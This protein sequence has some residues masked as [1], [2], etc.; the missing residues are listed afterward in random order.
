M[1]KFAKATALCAALFLAAM[2]IIDSGSAVKGARDALSL[3]SGVLIPSLFPFMVTS[4]FIADLPLPR[5]AEAVLS[6]LMRAAFR[7]PCAAAPAVIF[8]LI[9][10][11][12]VGARMAQRLFLRGEIT[13]EQAQR[14]LLFCVNAGPAFVIGT[15]GASLLS[16]PEAGVILFASLSISSLLLGCFL[17]FMP[18]SCADSP[19]SAGKKS[20]QSL[21]L[22]LVNA[23]SE[24]SAGIVSV[25]AWVIFFGSVCALIPPGAGRNAALCVLEVTGG[26][27]ESAGFSLPVTASVL[28]FGGL[29]VHCQC[30][31]LA[32]KIPIKPLMFFSARVLNAVFAA[33]IC[34]GLTRVF[35]QSI[36]TL[37]HS[38][39]AF[40]AAGAAYPPAAC[41]L[42]FLCALVI[43]DLDTCEKVC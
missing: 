35:P 16:S 36:S 14:L 40:T 19:Q 32:S 23:V 39:E 5:K 43:L 28:G 38:G 15:V 3:C 20:P 4:G 13:D 22:S 25:C 33:F 18:H 37:A 1:Q 21:S 9:G 10:G 41:A 12:P 11:Y 17:R 7:L 26:C 27:A 24:G 8:G 6:P 34:E 31:S 42:L 29:C 30:F 2:L